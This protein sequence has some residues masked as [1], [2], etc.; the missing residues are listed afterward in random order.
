MSAKCHK[1][2]LCNTKKGRRFGGTQNGAHLPR[3]LGAEI[4]RRWKRKVAALSSL[5]RLECYKGCRSRS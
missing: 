1:R 3:P 5:H 4:F 2:T